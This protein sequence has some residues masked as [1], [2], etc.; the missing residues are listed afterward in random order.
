[1]I[2]AGGCAAAAAAPPHAS[3]P[4]RPRSPRRASSSSARAGSAARRRRPGPAAAHAEPDPA[5]APRHDSHDA[6][7]PARTSRPGPAATRPRRGHRSPPRSRWRSRAR[8]RRPSSALAG[9]RVER[10]EDP[11]ELPGA[12]PG[13]WSTTRRSP[14]PRRRDSHMDRVVRR[15]ELERVLEQVD[16]HPLDLRGVDTH[17][18]R[19]V[20]GHDLDPS[21]PGRPR[22][23]PP[24]PARRPST[25]RAPA[26]RRRPGAGRGR[27]GSR[28]AD[29]ADRLDGD[30]VEELARGR[31]R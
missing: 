1:M 29:S 11:L 28:P 13:P 15:G 9:T 18:R 14:P 23:A 7:A 19:L 17:E 6:A 8:G 3:R 31:R 30:R 25:A 22:R 10:L 24:R 2:A 27:A 12:D 4:C 20:T 16:E 5:P 26:R 21:A